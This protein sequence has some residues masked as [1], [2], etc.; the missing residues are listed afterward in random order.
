[1]SHDD[2]SII[3][4]VQPGRQQEREIVLQSGKGLVNPTEMLPQL[5]NL[6]CM[7]TETCSACFGASR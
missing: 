7:S 6:I 3:N 1:M 4:F 5:W 2:M